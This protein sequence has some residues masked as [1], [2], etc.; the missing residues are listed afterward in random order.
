MNWKQIQ[1]IE[2]IDQIKRESI[3]NTVMIFKHSTR[4][5]ISSAALSRIERG[6]NESLVEKITPY[7]LDL[8]KFRDLSNVIAQEFG[9]EHQSPQVILIKNGV[10]TYNESHHMIRV[11]EITGV[12]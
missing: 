3:D 2:D 1:T 8:I 9:V 11:D 7:Y 4:C 5:S 6:W 10:A 12:I